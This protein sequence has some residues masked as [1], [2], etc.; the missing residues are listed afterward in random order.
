[1][2][3]YAT[4]AQ[5]PERALRKDRHRLQADDVAR[6]AG[7]VDLAGRDHGGDPAVEIAVDPVG[8]VLPRRPVAGDRV[9]VAV[10][11]ARG[12]GGA[13]GIDDR[14]GAL[15]VDVLETS[16][17]GDLAI[18]GHDRIGIQDRLLQ[19]PR[20]QQPD[21]ADH[22][23]VRAGRLGCIVGHQVFPFR[24][25]PSPGRCGHLARALTP[26]SSWIIHSYT[27]DCRQMN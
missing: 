11:Q 6:T 9:D 12:D 1:M 5:R 24:S 20:Q 8:L 16:D 18:L 25:M 22:Q 15:G 2:H 10:D 27:N 21:I 19:S 23:L 17:R 3:L 26:G 4:R 14:G 7:H 13:V